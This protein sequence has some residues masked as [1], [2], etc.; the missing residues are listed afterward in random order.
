VLP[1]VDPVT[2]LP[3]L[4]AVVSVEFVAVVAVE[5]EAVVELPPPPPHPIIKM[6][7]AAISPAITLFNSD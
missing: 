7:A 6:T 3:V 4:V 5:V 1:D 2:V